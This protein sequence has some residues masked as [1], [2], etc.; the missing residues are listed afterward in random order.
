MGYVWGY[1]GVRVVFRE[2]EEEGW[3]Y[4]RSRDLGGVW[5]EFGWERLWGRFGGTVGLFEGGFRGDGVTWGEMGGIWGLGVG[6]VGVVWGGFGV[7]WGHF[8]GGGLWASQELFLGLRTSG[9][10][11]GSLAPFWP[12]R[13]PSHK[14]F[15]GGGGG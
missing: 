7:M 9:P 15:L 14:L 2:L 3:C 1:G 11:W 5:G 13:A 10:F 8:A 6:D 12:H 4:L